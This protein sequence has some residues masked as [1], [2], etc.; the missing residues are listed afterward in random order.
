[1]PTTIELQTP[2]GPMEAYSAAPAGNARGAVIVIQEAFGL[3]EHIGVVCDRFAAE[4]FRAI[5]PAMFHRGGHPAPV[6]AY[7]DIPAVFDILQQLT[8]EGIA[9]DVA[10]TVAALRSEGFGPGSIGITGF[11]MGGSITFM[12]CTGPGVDCGVTYYGGGLKAARFGMPA[13]VDL[14]S[15]LCV[16][17]MGHYG[18]LDQG[19]PVAE[20][21]ELRDAIAAAGVDGTIHRY[22]QADHGFNC[23]D[24][25]AVYNAEAAAT[26]WARTIEFFSSHLHR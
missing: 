12:A 23:E 20:V 11:C 25:P 15:E 16:P 19:I 3:T 14:A 1:M 5:A 21:E 22:D 4:G 8:A 9:M 7:D 10:A 6:A 2:D 17:W 18:D 26:A 24:R 13:L